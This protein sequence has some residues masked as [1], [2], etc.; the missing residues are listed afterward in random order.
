[1]TRFRRLGRLPALFALLVFF[2][3]TNFCLVG[4][5]S[6]GTPVGAKLNCGMYAKPAAAAASA[7]VSHCPMH[8]ASSTASSKAAG[9]QKSAARGTS[10]CCLALSPT[11]ATAA[12]KIASV[13]VKLAIDLASPITPLAAPAILTL[14]PVAPRDNGPPNHLAP[15]PLRGRAPPLL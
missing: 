13:P 9:S 14:S 8:A 11:T 4:A 5:L 12:P 2:T 10:P 15:S 1:M 7:P 3:G 6:A